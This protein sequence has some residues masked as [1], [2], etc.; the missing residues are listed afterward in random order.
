MRIIHI[1]DYSIMK[2][3][4]MIDSGDIDEVIAFAKQQDIFAEKI[5]RYQ[6]T[7]VSKVKQRLEKEGLNLEIVKPD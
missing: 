6:K 3:F 4:K 1:D 2:I 5:N 7:V